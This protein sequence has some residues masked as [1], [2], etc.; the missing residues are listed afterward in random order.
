MESN[1]TPDETT[2]PQTSAYEASED[3]ADAKQ[4]YNGSAPDVRHRCFICYSDEPDDELPEDWVTPCSCTLEGHHRCLLDWVNDLEKQGKQ[5][6]CPLCKSHIAVLDRW[7]PAVKFGDG[8]T[9]QVRRFAPWVVGTVFGTGF[10]AG[11]AAYGEN[12]LGVFAG[13]EATEAYVFGLALD[14]HPSDEELARSSLRYLG[15]S[16]IGPALVLNRMGLG[17]VV[18]VPTTLLVSRSLCGFC[19]CSTFADQIQF[20]PV[21]LSFDRLE[22]RPPHLATLSACGLICLSICEGVVWPVLQSSA[23]CNRQARARGE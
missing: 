14:H 16:M 11:S 4:A 13:P 23:P 20:T 15:L 3:L 17:E 2:S 10:V 22:T 19:V 12:A 8:L 9:R 21:C 6:S 5:I 18:L 7:D 1:P